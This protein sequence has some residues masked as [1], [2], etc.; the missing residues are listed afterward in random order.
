M[1][2]LIILSSFAVGASQDAGA[3]AGIDDLFLT[4]GDLVGGA[5][6]AVGAA[7]LDVSGEFGRDD[8]ITGSP[9]YHKSKGNEV[10]TS[11]YTTTNEYFA[12]T[13]T[14]LEEIDGYYADWNAVYDAIEYQ[15]EHR[16]YNG[17]YT[18]LM[19][20]VDGKFSVSQLVEMGLLKPVTLT[21]DNIYW[22]TNVGYDSTGYVKDLEAR[23]A[24]I[25]LL[26]SNLKQVDVTKEY[27]LNKIR[28]YNSGA[29]S[30]INETIEARF[31]GMPGYGGDYAL[32]SSF[33]YGHFTGY[34][35]YYGEFLSVP[36][37]SGSFFR[38]TGDGIKYRRLG[39]VGGCFNLDGFF[40]VESYGVGGASSKYGVYGFDCPYDTSEGFV[41]FRDEQVLLCYVSDIS[42]YYNYNAPVLMDTL[43]TDK[44]NTYCSYIDGRIDFYQDNDVDDVLV[45]A[46]DLYDKDGNKVQDAVYNI[47]F[48]PA[49]VTENVIG[50]VGL[51][52]NPAAGVDNVVVSE[53]SSGSGLGDWLDNF[54]KWL[55]QNLWNLLQKIWSGIK[56]IPGQIGSAIE[57]GI[58]GIKSGLEGF[59]DWMKTT[60]WDVVDSISTTL[61]NLWSWVCDLWD[62]LTGLFTALFVPSADYWDGKLSPSTLL[63]D[64]FKIVG[65]VQDLIM[66]LDSHY[67]GPPLSLSFQWFDT[68]DVENYPDLHNLHTYGVN[69][70]F[71]SSSQVTI[72]DAL[73]LILIVLAVLACIRIFMGVFGVYVNSAVNVTVR[74]TKGG[75]SK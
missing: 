8:P 10:Y 31:S 16:F 23:K 40:Q 70:D 48:S 41:G 47:P 53:P 75:G 6:V 5:A 20:L 2:F 52:N 11:T 45:Y 35:F 24:F 28:L 74:D 54:W 1:I 62:W 71:W 49:A 26:Q 43:D 9:F 50:A 15:N 46:P 12:K 69:F 32:T 65:Q 29:L 36:D 59:W 51:V 66:T 37:E 68:S 67:G 38:V 21:D 33:S 22:V 25:Q 44:I 73:N 63:A 13:I 55:T 7:G 64:R 42:D 3:I 61:E 39:V 60:F 14:A 4:L 72:R 57:S 34:H 56:D 58:N 27:F 19:D 30:E 18:F 17:G